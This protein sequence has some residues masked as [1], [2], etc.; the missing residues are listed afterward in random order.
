MY[1]RRILSHCLNILLKQTFRI[2]GKLTSLIYPRKL[3][4]KTILTK[5]IIHDSSI[6][7]SD[8]HWEVNQL[9]QWKPTSNKSE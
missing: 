6:Y 2:F 8:S 9:M 7:T 3:E 4:L 5:Y 1:S